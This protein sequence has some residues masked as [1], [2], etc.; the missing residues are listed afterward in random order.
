MNCSLVIKTDSPANDTQT[1]CEIA[2]T[3]HRRTVIVSRKAFWDVLG[4]SYR[5]LYGADPRIRDAV[6]FN[7]LNQ[8]RYEPYENL[9]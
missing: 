9:P 3:D 7:T 2:Q 5:K 6:A 1:A 8:I 4:A